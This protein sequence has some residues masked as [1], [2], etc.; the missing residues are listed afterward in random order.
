MRQKKM[1][2]NLSSTL[3]TTNIHSPLMMYKCF[4][5]DSFEFFGSLNSLKTLKGRKDL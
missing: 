3:L 5:G 1:S 2:D 4:V